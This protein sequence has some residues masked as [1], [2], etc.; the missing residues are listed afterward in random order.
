M[1]FSFSES[2]FLIFILI[3]IM[4]FSLNL[5]GFFEIFLSQRLL[6]KINNSLGVIVRSSHFFSECFA[7]LIG[8][9]L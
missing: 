2:F 6:Y 3:I 1:G 5:L 7:T 9:T 8:N 4:L